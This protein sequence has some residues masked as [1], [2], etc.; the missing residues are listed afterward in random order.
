LLQAFQLALAN[1]AGNNH[2]SHSSKIECGENPTFRAAEC[3]VYTGNSLI[4]CAQMAKDSGRSFRIYGLDTFKGLPPISESDNKW[5]PADA[6]YRHSILFSDTSI[7]I[8]TQKIIAAGITGGI[9]LFQ[10]LFNYSLP[11]LPEQTYH[12]VNIDCDLYEPHLECLEY[13][14]PRMERGGIVFFDDYHSICFP[15]AAKAIDLFM[16]DK[17]EK[18]MH[19]RFGNDA[20]NHTKAFFVKY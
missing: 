11:L 16:L 5:A 20:P 10:G 7:E 19:L 6:K 1:S 4:A 12:F 8:V 18:L 14:Y 9:Q 3:G 17:P 13:F 2:L 15:M